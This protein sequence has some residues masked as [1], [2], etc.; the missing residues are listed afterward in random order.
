MVVVS[1]GVLAAS[2]WEKFP[3]AGQYGVLLAYTLTFWA[4]SSWAKRQKNLHLTAQTLQIVTLL[5]VPINFWA[6]D[7][8]GLWRYHGDWAV[9]IA[10]AIILTWMTGRIIQYQYEQLSGKNVSRSIALN[11]LGLS[12]LHWGWGFASFSLVA[13]YLGT[14]GTAAATVYQVRQQQFQSI[15]HDTTSESLTT[16]LGSKQDFINYKKAALVVYSL[17]VLLN[18]AIF[19]K[20]VNIAEMGLALGA[21]SKLFWAVFLLVENPSPKKSNRLT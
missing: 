10:A 14:V 1:S 9:V 3:A 17:G 7:S 8:F 6:M 11:H 19:V 15:K 12:Y 18:R 5:L 16:V 13:V 2:Q 20:G 21:I 4:I